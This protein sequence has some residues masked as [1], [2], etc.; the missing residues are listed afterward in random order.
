MTGNLSDAARRLME[1]RLA[2][3]SAPVSK[4]RDPRP[5][6]P[7]LAPAQRRLWFIHQLTQGSL[8]Y[9]V[10]TAYR[11]RGP[12]DTEALERAVHLVVRRHE[13]L[14]TCY[15]ADEH[16]EPFQRVLD[17]DAG[18]RTPVA[19]HDLTSAADPVA[20]ALR[21]AGSEADHRF[22]LDAEGPLRLWLATLGPD[23]HVLGIV[24]HHIAFDRESLAILAGEL[25]AAYRAE[26]TAGT[27][28]LPPL[29][30]QYADF[31][32]W[33]TGLTGTQEYERELGYWRETL[34][35]LAPVLEL[36]AD[37]QR[38]K[39]PTYRAGEAAIHIDAETADRLRALST[40]RGASLFMTCLAAFQ[41]LLS[42]YTA[43]TA[44][45]VGCPVNGRAKVAYEGLIGFFANSLPIGV[46]L[47]DDPAFAAMVD[48]TRES[49]LSA[50]AHQNVP[51]DRI[52][53]ELSPVR[54]LSR[55][56]LV[57]VWFDLDA[58]DT[59]TAADLLA[60]PGVRSEYFTEGR[61]RTRFDAEMHL[62]ERADGTIT[63]R[64][65]YAQ[66]LFAAETANGLCEHYANFL[67][68][69]AADPGLRLS[70]VPLFSARQRSTLL[71]DWSVGSG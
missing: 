52:V 46:H 68:A 49:L 17:A 42:R 50:H 47:D 24:V 67:A 6:R 38:P 22:R 54:D 60:L 34:G 36:P 9:N 10:P 63:G 35:R 55:N 57:Q 23:D 30:A 51:F 59:G 7:P 20:E 66:D 70:R 32:L 58:G 31:A 37:H 2:G 4:E 40:E 13:V 64:L 48:R 16:G 43:E 25:S 71:D 29:D 19:R 41:G 69:V 21:I 8:A 45:A 11:L 56:P 1:L 12:L 53:R 27:P 62:G 33:Q 18:P 3:L 15:P 28:E 26:A 61:V 5:E 14:R 44:L 39:E 65:L